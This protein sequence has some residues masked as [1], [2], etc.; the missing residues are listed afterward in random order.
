MTTNIGGL[1]R[2]V[3]MSLKIPPTQKS[4]LAGR[5]FS[6]FTGAPSGVV[7]KV[8]IR[9]RTLA[10]GWTFALGEF[11]HQQTTRRHKPPMF[12]ND[13]AALRRFRRRRNLKRRSLA[14]F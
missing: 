2:R 14:V 10:L 12:V 6:S 4:S 9:G 3:V 5:G 7:E 1:C 13:T 8:E 11:R